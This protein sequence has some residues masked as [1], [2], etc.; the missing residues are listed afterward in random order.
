MTTKITAHQ[1]TFLKAIETGHTTTR[2]LMQHL[3]IPRNSVSRILRVLRDAGLVSFA[4]LPGTQSAKQFH[5]TAPLE[6]LDFEIA[7]R[8]THKTYTPPSEEELRY[9]AK[10]SDEDKLIGQR[11]IA[12]HQKKY[13]ERTARSMK[14][15][16]AK[17]RNLGYCR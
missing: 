4:P 14:T 8:L 9:I 3:S 11:R 6:D 10:I 13:P 12:A 16:V 17:A 1:H 7:Y 2:A 15:L 5:L